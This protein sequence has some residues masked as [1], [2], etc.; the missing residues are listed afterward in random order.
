MDSLDG[1]SAESLGLRA[2]LR[3]DRARY[4]HGEPVLLIL[5]VRNVSALPIDVVLE[6]RFQ[7][8]D[9]KAPL[10]GI[11]KLIVRHRH[12]PEA[13]GNTGGH[14]EGDYLPV[15]SAMFHMGGVETIPP[16]E[17]RQ[18]RTS[19]GAGFW[20][21]DGTGNDGP[22]LRL[23]RGRYEVAAELSATS[24]VSQQTR[25]RHPQLWAGSLRL[26]SVIFEVT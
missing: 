17:T 9:H 4:R 13:A 7:N 22:R 10:Y 8:P 1:W 11:A 3:T 25:Q 24:F 21:S 12:P 20:S 15:P 16:G 5:E 23:V 14:R 26:P 19:L 6:D 18:A 2:R